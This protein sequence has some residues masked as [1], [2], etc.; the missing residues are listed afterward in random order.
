MNVGHQ[1][2]N[3]HNPLYCPYGI[4]N[5]AKFWIQG[6]MDFNFVCVCTS[7]RWLN[8]LMAGS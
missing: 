8:C 1:V 7:A 5:R 6:C 2:H 4:E 3:T